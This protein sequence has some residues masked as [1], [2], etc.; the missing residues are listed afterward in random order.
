[1]IVRSI[2]TYSRETPQRIKEQ[3]MSRYSLRILNGDT[4]LDACIRGY[5]STLSAVAAIG[6]PVLSSL[7]ILIAIKHLADIHQRMNKDNK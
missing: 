5:I 7:Y 2:T 6:E 3:G 1:M 4:V